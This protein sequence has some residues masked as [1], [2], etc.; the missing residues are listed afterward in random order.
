[1]SFLLKKLKKTLEEQALEKARQK[2]QEE[3][4]NQ[5]RIK[6]FKKIVGY[7]EIKAIMELALTSEYNIN[8]LLNGTAGTGKTQFLKCIQDYY[9]EISGFLDCSLASQAGLRDFL[10]ANQHIE[11]LLLDEISRLTQKDQETLLNLAQYGRFTYTKN[12]RHTD[13]QFDNLKIIATS[14]N[15]ECLISPI[16]DRFDVFELP[17]YTIEQIKD[18]ARQNLK[19]KIKDIDLLE[20]ILNKAV[21]DLNLTTARDIIDMGKMIKTY[22]DLDL[23]IQAKKKFGERNES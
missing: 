2:Q 6:I 5:P 23:Y 10:E 11:I 22:E 20:E 18:I 7:D 15:A 8:I 13:L 17:P 21:N 16:F 12:K 1:M 9:P 3:Y 14:N 19:N 4:E